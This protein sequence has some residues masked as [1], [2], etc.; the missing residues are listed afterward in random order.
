MKFVISLTICIIQIPFMII[1]FLGT[2]ICGAI[3]VGNQ[4]AVYLSKWIN[5]PTGGV[6]QS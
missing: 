1:G 4:Y 6:G 2:F 3:I 5:R